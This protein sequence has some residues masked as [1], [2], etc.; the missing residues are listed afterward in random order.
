M[1]HFEMSERLTKLM[2]DIK[3]RKISTTNSSPRKIGIINI[4]EKTTVNRNRY[5]PA[6]R[7]AKRQPNTLGQ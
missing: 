4:R 2:M 1:G 6:I 5:T 7:L 3:T